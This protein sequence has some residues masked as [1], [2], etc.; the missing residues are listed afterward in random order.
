MIDSP[1]EFLRFSKRP[2]QLA[3]ELLLSPVE[4]QAAVVSKPERLPLR[5]LRQRTAAQSA[6]VQAAQRLAAAAA[7]GLASL[8]RLLSRP[9][10][11]APAPTWG[12][13][14]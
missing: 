13:T 2:H 4:F 11:R 3:G 9:M 14:G 6:V 10:A 1:N 5:P 8:P 12:R 7:A